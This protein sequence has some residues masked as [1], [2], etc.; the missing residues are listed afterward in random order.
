MRRAEIIGLDIWIDHDARIVVR[1]HPSV[2]LE[3]PMSTPPWR[4]ASRSAKAFDRDGFGD[5]QQFAA[6]LA[7]HSDRRRSGDARYLKGMGAGDMMP[8]AHVLLTGSR[9]RS[10]VDASLRRSV[11]CLGRVRGELLDV[12]KSD[13]VERFRGPGWLRARWRRHRVFQPY[14]RVQLTTIRAS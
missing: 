14:T 13:A 5:I 6:H 10:Q 8:I 9:R 4:A 3:K 1:L 11:E 12:S 7:W 2:M